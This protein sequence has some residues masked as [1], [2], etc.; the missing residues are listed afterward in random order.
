MAKS[1][2][3]V[4]AMDL[5]EKVADSDSSVVIEGETGTGKELIARSLHRNSPRR[6]GP[7]LP[8]NCGA[9]PEHLLESE[10][11]GHERGAFT[12]SYTRKLGFLET[13][14]GGTVLLNEIAV[15]SSNLQVKLLRVSCRSGRCAGWEGRS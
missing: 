14:E 3:M 8:I 5:V 12:G 15:L 7:F 13:A 2:A 6:D 9:L 4:E 1:A 11:F 10:L